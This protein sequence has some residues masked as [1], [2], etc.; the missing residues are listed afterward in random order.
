MRWS[1]A[2]GGAT[3][4]I[5]R[6]ALLS[7]STSKLLLNGGLRLHREAESETATATPDVQELE[8]SVWS[9]VAVIIIIISYFSK[10]AR[11]VVSFVIGIV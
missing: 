8:V 7:L 1:R 3:A 5:T 10:R 11:V 6:T 2:L 4:S 9:T